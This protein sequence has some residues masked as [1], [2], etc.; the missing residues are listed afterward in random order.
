MGRFGLSV[1]SDRF[2][3]KAAKKQ[4]PVR[5]VKKKICTDPDQATVFSHGSYLA[6]YMDAR[7]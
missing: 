4:K 3:G 5:A 6:H 1:L 7:Q 2:F